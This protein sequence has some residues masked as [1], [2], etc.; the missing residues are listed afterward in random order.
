MSVGQGKAETV[1]LNKEGRHALFEASSSLPGLFIYTGFANWG[2]RDS[3][4]HAAG[5]GVGNHIWMET[6]GEE[7]PARS[8]S[9]APSVPRQ[10]AG[11]NYNVE[12]ETLAWR[13]GNKNISLRSC[14]PKCL[15]RQPP[16]KRPGLS[17]KTN[18][19]EREKINEFSPMQ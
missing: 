4:Q 10:H 7:R 16:P 19:T 18:G 5:G 3:S 12:Q 14:P 9:F 11:I 2:I 6:K 13:R 1:N 8:S 15:K 17:H